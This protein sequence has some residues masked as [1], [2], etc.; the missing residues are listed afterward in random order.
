MVKKLSAIILWAVAFAYVEAAVVEYIRAL[1]HPLSKGG[2]AFPLPT[3]EQM[4]MMGDE[5]FRRLLIELGRESATLVML[6]AAAAAAANNRREG[7]AYFVIAFG[8]WDVFYYVWLKIFLDWPESL[9]T[10]DLL[11]LLPVPW[12]SPVAAPVI[13]SIVMI[14]SG[15]TVLGFEAKNRP[16]AAGWAHWAALT[17]AGSIVIV[18]FCLDYKNIMAGGL[19]SP[20]NWTLFLIGLGAGVAAFAELV[21]RNLLGRLE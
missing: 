4:Q 16:L 12:V 10:W 11:F 7:W 18:S 19:P 9:M 21:G 14:I 6:A 17:V 1:Y 2:F 15:L 8:V 20:F 3:L 5:H 13:I